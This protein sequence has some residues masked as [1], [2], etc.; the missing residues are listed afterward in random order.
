MITLPSLCKRFVAS[1]ILILA[2]VATNWVDFVFIVQ[3]ASIDDIGGKMMAAMKVMQRSQRSMTQSAKMPSAFVNTRPWKSAIFVRAR[4]ASCIGSMQKDIINQLRDTS[5]PRLFSCSSFTSFIDQSYIGSSSHISRISMRMLSKVNNA[6][7]AGEGLISIKLSRLTEDEQTIY[8][9]LSALSQKIRELD[10]SYYGGGAST[11]SDEEYDALARREAEL[12]TKYPDLLILLEEESG[13][14]KDA[15]RYGGRVGQTYKELKESDSSNEVKPTKKKKNTKTSPKSSSTKKRQ[16]RKH[17]ENAPMQSLDNAMDTPEVVAWV[18][19]VKKLL[20]SAATTDTDPDEGNYDANEQNI[21]VTIIAEPKIDGLSLSLRYELDDKQSNAE[22]LTYNFAW[23]ATR[24]DGKQGEDVSEAV[25]SAWIKNDAKLLDDQQFTLPNSLHIAADEQFSP[26]TTL[27][28]RGEVVLPQASF[29]EFT[30][31]VTTS[32]NKTT[33]FSNARNAASGILLRS[34]EP[35]SED[36]LAQTKWLQ[37]RL[38]FYAYDIVASNAN[39]FDSSITWLSSKFT[40]DATKMRDALT[41]L[42]FQVPDPVATEDITFSFENDTVEADI[43]ALLDYHRKI[44]TD[45]DDRATS[46]PYHIDGVVYKVSSLVDR[47]IC[48]SSSRTPRWAIAHK[49]PPQVAVT[50][51]NDIEIQVGRTGALT[52]VAILEPVDLGGVMVARASLHNFHYAK[53]ILSPTREGITQ[54][55]TDASTVNKGIEVLVSRAGDVIPQVMK[56]IFDD[57]GSSVDGVISLEPPQQCPA[58]G[59]STTFDFVN[60]SL[61]RKSRKKTNDTVMKTEQVNDD[62]ND[63]ND[64]EADSG[65]VLRCSG[66]QLLCQPRAVNAMAYAYSRAGLDVKGVSKSKLQHLMDE[67]I[68]RYPAD[69]FVAFGD[70]DDRDSPLR[71]GKMILIVVG[72]FVHAFILSRKYYKHLSEMLSKIADLPG[73]GEISSQNVADSIRLVSAEG[74]SFSRYIY[75]LGIPFIGTH[76]SQLVASTYGS[77]TSFLDALDEAAKYVDDVPIHDESGGSTPFEALAEVKGIGPAAIA[78]LL[79]FSKEEVLMRAAKDLSKALKVHDESPPTSKSMVV[80]N[81]EEPS[82]FEGMTVVFTGTLPGMSR[83][84]AQNTVK[85]LGAKA[86]PNT[87][88]KSTS[89]VIEGEKGGKKAKQAKDMGIRVIGYEEFIAMIS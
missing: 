46:L 56:R 77:V 75:A 72:R 18:N 52:P 42:G 60:T 2:A 63:D 62:S 33:A 53:K 82:P 25:K 16:K 37:S 12:C 27:E 20:L 65:Q 81:S 22:T 47:R 89:L 31:N 43:Q 6:E 11:I 4:T 58:C 29:D 15:T 3:G 55:K 48:G 79:S 32:N 30:R 44:L 39:D 38:Q 49:F 1:T 70:S 34:K 5:P 10:E 13:L 35:T 14:G 7:T 68:I 73:W 24:G 61:Q 80:K 57:D 41:L 74:V 86:T 84:V 69:L 50:R 45:R 78:A 88:S 8:Q 17:L 59:S 21:S 85:E 66:P 83:T 28:I 67:N 23:G 40:A 87:V 36:A 19:R 71:Q 64:V 51:L 9:E 76:A 26:P 54:T